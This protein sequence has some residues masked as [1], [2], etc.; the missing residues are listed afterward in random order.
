MAQGK[1]LSARVVALEN[2]TMYE[3]TQS[4]M[5][6]AQSDTNHHGTKSQNLTRRLRNRKLKK[7]TRA[8]SASRRG[9]DGSHLAVRLGR[10]RELGEA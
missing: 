5:Q 9:R 3:H 1:Y 6:I 7:P 8:P 10:R 2:T 4:Q